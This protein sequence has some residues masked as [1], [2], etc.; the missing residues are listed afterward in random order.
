MWIDSIQARTRDQ[1][2]AHSDSVARGNK[3]IS[4]ASP[5]QPRAT[6]ANAAIRV[7]SRFIWSASIVGRV[8][9]QRHLLDTG[10]RRRRAA[11]EKLPS[12]RMRRDK[13][14]CRR[15]K[16]GTA[17]PDAIACE[18]HNTFLLP[19]RDMHCMLLAD[20][21]VGVLTVYIKKLLA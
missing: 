6:P 18:E 12:P 5:T 2:I 1:K 9:A 8:P 11:H 13:V 16:N 17:S 4:A 3:D 14:A 15:L 10:H 20:L 19:H 7:E 21:G